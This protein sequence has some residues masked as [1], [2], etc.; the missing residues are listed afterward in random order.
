MTADRI[1]FQISRV[2]AVTQLW[3]RLVD[4]ASLGITKSNAVRYPG[5]GFD[6]REESNS[7]GEGLKL[8]NSAED[9]GW[10][11]CALTRRH[12]SDF[13]SSTEFVNVYFGLL[14]MTGVVLIV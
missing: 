12:Y 14:R 1:T 11:Q 7:T 5:D 8:A 13:G 2:T 10:Q 3:L 9:G 4:Q 6:L